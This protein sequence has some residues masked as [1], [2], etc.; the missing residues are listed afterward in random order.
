M[1]TLEKTWSNI[2]LRLDFAQ[3]PFDDD[4]VGQLF[5]VAFTDSRLYKSTLDFWN[6]K[7][8]VDFEISNLPGVLR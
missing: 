1:E 5:A 7:V 6:M 4:F 3:T 2:L 8:P